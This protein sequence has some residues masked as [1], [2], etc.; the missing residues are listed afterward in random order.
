M[1]NDPKQ[2]LVRAIIDA[3]VRH[4]GVV[5]LQAQACGALL[6]LSV[7][8]THGAA[9]A[10]FARVLFAS[11]RTAPMRYVCAVPVLFFFSFFF[12]FFPSLV[13]PLLWVAACV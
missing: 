5:A 8:G 4:V 13:L 3:M 11:R 6:N 12:L 7:P 10:M 1:V 9:V 2:K